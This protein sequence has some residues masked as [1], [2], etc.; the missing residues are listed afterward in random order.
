VVFDVPLD[1]L[2]LRVLIVEDPMISFLQEIPQN[3]SLK[4]F[5]DSIQNGVRE[6]LIPPTGYY[7]DQVVFIS[8]YGAE[9]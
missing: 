6:Y 5:P 3:K 4:K 8:I 7:F 9:G 2:E 1:Y